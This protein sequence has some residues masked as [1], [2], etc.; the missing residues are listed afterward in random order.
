MKT[1]VTALL[2]SFGGI[3]NVVIVVMAVWL[4]FA[5]L[6]VNLFAGKSQYCT[7]NKFLADNERECNYY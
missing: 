7:V 4:M 2:S 1:I 5:I 6:A 3:F